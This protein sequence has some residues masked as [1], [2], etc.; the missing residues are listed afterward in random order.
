MYISEQPSN[1]LDVKQSLKAA[2]VIRSL[3]RPDRSLYLL[4]H[5]D[6]HCMH[7]IVFGPAFYIK[8][9]LSFS[10]RAPEFYVGKTT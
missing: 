1:Y 6:V 3:C 2:Q 4:C 10:K 7:V 9:A 8:N 5:F